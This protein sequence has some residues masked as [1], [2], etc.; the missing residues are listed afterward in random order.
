[1]VLNRR[2]V[3]EENIE[4]GTS[5]EQHD[6][7]L[8][9]QLPNAA[10]RRS[11]NAPAPSASDHDG[12]DEE[13]DSRLHHDDLASFAHRSSASVPRDAVRESTDT[14]RNPLRPSQEDCTL[15]CYSMKATD[16]G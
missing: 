9:R 1:M 3:V 11:S 14:V 12:D 2:L 5:E 6:L 16:R 4:S 7:R 10:A 13:E 8:R 15:F